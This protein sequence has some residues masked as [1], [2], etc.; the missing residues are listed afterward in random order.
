MSNA[1]A[2]AAEITTHDEFVA[3]YVANITPFAIAEIGEDTVASAQ[4]G[5][6]CDAEYVASRN[7][8]IARLEALS[9]EELAAEYVANDAEHD[10]MIALDDWA[11]YDV[12]DHESHYAEQWL[13]KSLLEDRAV[14]ARYCSPQPLT[15]SPFAGLVAA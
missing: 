8:H 9:N 3:F 7:H 5:S 12:D 1:V 11:E 13:I 10:R 15:H 14:R 6:Y 4:A 2:T